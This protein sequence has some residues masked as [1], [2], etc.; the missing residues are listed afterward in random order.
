MIWISLFVSILFSETCWRTE[1]IDFQVDDLGY[2]YTIEDFSVIKFNDRGDTLF[3]FSRM[4]L[5]EVS[6]LDVSN[7]LRPLVFYKETSN[8]C[9]LDNT[10]S[11]QRLLSF[12]N[13]NFGMV[14]MIASGVSQQFWVYDA[15]NKELLLVDERMDI[16][17]R[18]GY[19]P[20][21]TGIDIDFAGMAERHEQLFIADSNFGIWVFDRFGTLTHRLP[22]SGIQGIR[23][24]A[25]AIIVCANQEFWK[26][27]YETR[28]IEKLD[29]KADH[30]DQVK[31]KQYF[32]Q[33]NQI[34][35]R[36]N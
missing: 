7:P 10:L 2:I 5:G 25:D 36:Q 24:H 8:L 20:G 13:N 11:E 3:V 21:V 32:F 1:A 33:Q 12:W 14:E 26:Y 30:F 28:G 6:Q 23:A 9:V 22:I 18:S 27:S 19:L 29:V 31:G 15:I 4:D 16:R 35:V 34:C 17:A